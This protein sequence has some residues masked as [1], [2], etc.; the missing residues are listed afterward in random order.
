MKRATEEVEDD[1]L[2]L[3]VRRQHE[4]EEH[5]WRSVAI[6]ILAQAG[7]EALSGRQD[8]AADA[9]AFLLGQGEYAESLQ[10]WCDVAG[11]SIG[12]IQRR[13][14]APALAMGSR[15]ITGQLSAGS[16]RT[17]AQFASLTG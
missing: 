7:E 11:V 8:V 16:A 6:A 3:D 4:E 15:T 14:V 17:L 1:D 10:I 2:R 5:P 12:V 9:L 13:F